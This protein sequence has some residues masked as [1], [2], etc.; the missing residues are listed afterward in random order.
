MIVF[1]ISPASLYARSFIVP[2]LACSIST[3]VRE[4]LSRKLEPSLFVSKVW[5]VVLEE[6]ANKSSPEFISLN[7]LVLPGSSLVKSPS[8]GSGSGSPG[9]VSS[10][11]PP[12]LPSPFKS[13][14]NKFS[15]SFI[16]RLLVGE[17]RSSL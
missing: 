11:K 7:N 4:V 3:E 9:R 13:K 14:P 5:S 17:P 2:S 6:S 12:C 15:A 10:I 1:V 8:M 16:A